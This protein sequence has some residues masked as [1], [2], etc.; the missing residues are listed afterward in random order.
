MKRRAARAI[1]LHVHRILLVLAVAILGAAGSLA[2][3]APERQDA[4][5]NRAACGF[6]NIDIYFWPLGHKSVP[7]LKFPAYPAPHVEIYRAKKIAGTAQ[8]GFF[9][10]NGADFSETICAPV[11]DGAVPRWAAQ[12]AAATT[13]RR[14]IRCLFATPVEL[15]ATPITDKN[16]ATIGH[17]LDVTLGHTAKAYVTIRML[18][19]GKHTLRYAKKPCTIVKIPPE[20]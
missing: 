6:K 9:S 18:A 15:R 3:A 11:D 14:E 1:T 19:T 17:Q 7:K 13:K 12:S 5:A 8:I 20:R 16:G 2:V 4:L 10:V